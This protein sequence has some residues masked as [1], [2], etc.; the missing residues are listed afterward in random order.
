[1]SALSEKMRKTREMR[2]DCGN[3]K[4]LTVLRPTPLQWEEIVKSG[5]IVAG[6]IGLVIG[7]SGFVEMDFIPGGDPH[8]LPFDPE[9]CAEFLSDNPATF[10][11][12]AD[13]VI[14]GMTQYMEK[15]KAAVKN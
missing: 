3:G 4:T 8:P 10:S 9:A 12:V 15:K 14:D 11:S 7:W 2:V 1:M 6:V 5:N 13:A